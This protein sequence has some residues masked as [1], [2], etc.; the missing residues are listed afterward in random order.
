[1]PRG[2]A[3]RPRHRRPRGPRA[4]R[5]GL[6]PPEPHV[7]PGARGRLP[8]H[9]VPHRGVPPLGARMLEL[10][11]LTASHPH[12]TGPDRI[13]F[14]GVDITVG[15]GEILAL[16]GPSGCGKSTLLRIIAGLAPSTAGR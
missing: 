13:V 15:R 16:L 11:D 12:P 6:P 10:V 9:P 1:P 8:V 7:P 14:R 3:P 2:H 5:G 4:R